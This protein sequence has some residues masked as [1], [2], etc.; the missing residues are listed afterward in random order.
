MYIIFRMYDMQYDEYSD[1]IRRKN[2][3]NFNILS[4]NLILQ[5]LLKLKV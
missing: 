2:T 4:K 3:Y 5:D 1:I